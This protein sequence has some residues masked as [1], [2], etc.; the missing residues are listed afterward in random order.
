MGPSAMVFF[1]SETEDAVLEAAAP[2]AL[3]SAS[4]PFVG[5]DCRT[6]ASA[7]STADMF[8]Y[9]SVWNCRNTHTPA[10]EATPRAAKDKTQCKVARREADHLDMFETFG[11]ATD[12]SSCW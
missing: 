11:K 7:T 2:A 6:T 5:P 8:N 10:D 3:E 1:S 9:V 4:A 12:L